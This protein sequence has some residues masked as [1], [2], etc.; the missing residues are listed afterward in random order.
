MTGNISGV[1]AAGATAF[2]SIATTFAAF[3]SNAIPVAAYPPIPQF[4]GEITASM[5]AA[6]MRASNA[7]P[8]RCSISAPTTAA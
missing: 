4:A 7:F 1:A 6:A 2:A 8:P 5:N 3:A